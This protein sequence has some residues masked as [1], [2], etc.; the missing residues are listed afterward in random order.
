MLLVLTPREKSKQMS[1]VLTPNRRLA[2]FLQK[3][4][5]GFI[6]PLQTW[7]EDLWEVCRKQ[8]PTLPELLSPFEELLLWKR[9][10]LEANEDQ[11]QNVLAFDATL[12]LAKDAHY[13]IANWQIYSEDADLLSYSETQDAQIFAG[14]RKC[15]L[16]EL[17]KN[18]FCDH[19]QLI[20]KL[21]D[22]FDLYKDQLSKKIICF[23][24]NEWTPQQQ[25]FWEIFR[26]CGI[27]K[28]EK[29][30]SKI[31]KM[32][33]SEPCQSPQDEL[34]QAVFQAKLWLQENSENYFIDESKM[35]LQEQVSRSHQNSKIKI[36]IVIPDLENCREQVQEILQEYLPD[37]SFNIAAPKSLFSYPIIQSA[38]S[39]LS[40]IFYKISLEQWSK[41]LRNPYL[42]QS[43]NETFALSALDAALQERRQSEY[44]LKQFIEVLNLHRDLFKDNGEEKNKK[45]EKNENE[46][47][48]KDK[49]TDSSFITR[50][51]AIT[52]LIPSFKNKK[53]AAEWKE[54]ILQFLQ[55]LQ[56]TQGLNLTTEE[57]AVLKEWEALLEKYLS[58]QRILGPHSFKE[59]FQ[60]IKDLAQNIAYLQAQEGGWAPIQVLGLLESVGIPFDKLWVAGLHQEAWPKGP[61]PNPFISVNVQRKLKCPRACPEREYEIAK[62]YTELLCQ[63]AETIIFSYPKTI[64]DRTVKLSYL[65]SHLPQIENNFQQNQNMEDNFQKNQIDCETAAGEYVANSIE[66]RLETI[67][68]EAV[69]YNFSKTTTGALKLQ[70]NCPFRAFAEIRLQ[71]KP[72]VKQIL[73]L[74]PAERGEIVHDVLML[75]WSQIKTQAALN[76]LSEDE[77]SNTLTQLIQYGLERFENKTGRRLGQS[78]KNLELNRL[79]DLFTRFMSLE[80]SRPS[81]ETIALESKHAFKIAGLDLNLRIDRIDQLE[82]GQELLLDYKT[83]LVEVQSWFKDPILEPQLP[84]YCISRPKIPLGFSFVVLKA[85][86]IKYVGVAKEDLHIPGIKTLSKMISEGVSWESQCK[87]WQISLEKIAQSFKDG[88]ATIQPA[89]G[90][91]SCM[92]CEQSSFCRIRDSTFITNDAAVPI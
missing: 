85:N 12:E 38:F 13:L 21:I 56:W 84:L 51:V 7:L 26:G 86:E 55:T 61:N 45:E 54:L 18:H 19:A 29:H 41:L 64:E 69:P 74:T 77:L 59:A 3:N 4:S 88:V 23:G 63:G 9:V 70:A 42:C 10:I 80:K 39:C 82:N 8:D 53:S 75:F 36:G 14:W 30:Y 66:A 62:H 89:E 71:A 47:N 43:L 20:D 1:L 67:Q 28:I 2:L 58:L 35:I 81:F 68:P 31:P 6:L 34:T 49:E 90:E 15:Y 32:L 11:N 5:S 76:L 25:R 79:L 50:I 24:F 27:E 33:Y 52:T 83:G 73:G 78:F 48:D 72:L 44:S 22:Y 46:N 91:K 65:L 16:E 87:E 57:T 92:Y 37:K 17:E 40:M 60:I